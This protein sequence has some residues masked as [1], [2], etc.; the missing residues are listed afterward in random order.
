VPLDT[1]E[2][3]AMQRRGRGIEGLESRKRHEVESVNRPPPQSRPEI[4]RER[5]HFR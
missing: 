4:G 1:R 5:L 3:Q 2:A